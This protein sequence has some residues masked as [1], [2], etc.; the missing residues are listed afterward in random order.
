MRYLFLFIVISPFS[1][2]FASGW[3]DEKKLKPIEEIVLK[4]Q[5]ELQKNSRKPDSDEEERHG[6]VEDL[7]CKPGELRDQD[8]FCYHRLGTIPKL[9]E[10]FQEDLEVEKL[11]FQ[12]GLPLI[13]DKI[14][15]YEGPPFNRPFETYI[16]DGDR[17][18]NA[19][20]IPWQVYISL[21]NGRAFCGGSIV[22]D[23]WILTAAH[24]VYKYKAKKKYNIDYILAGTTNRKKG[25]RRFSI[26]KVIRHPSY[27]LR[28][29]VPH[30]DVA[31][32]KLNKKVTNNLT[33]KKIKLAD[34][35]TQISTHLRVSGWGW[36]VANSPSPSDQLLFVDIPPVD[37]RRCG[38]RMPDIQD[39][40]LC[41]GRS[42]G[43]KSACRGDSGGPA[44]LRWGGAVLVGVVS[45]GPGECGKKYGYSVF[46]RVSYFL[47]WIK[48]TMLRN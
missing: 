43:G 6:F 7:P 37:N 1:T 40:M 27:Y 44:T 30:Y 35:S 20:A 23:Y 26:K 19:Q 29:G 11:Q 41:A 12:E 38:R 3:F 15:K 13:K 14:K 9:G 10:E 47:N 4:S 28:N 8:G 2:A 32:I 21:E 17:V 22:H 33:A 16:I 18:P 25:G 48:R 36:T 42:A 5:A 24:C 45:W 39:Y 31:L 46:A 34:S